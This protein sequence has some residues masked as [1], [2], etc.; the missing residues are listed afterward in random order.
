MWLCVY[1]SVHVCRLCM[2]LCMYMGCVRGGAGMWAVYVAVRACGLCTW[3]CV[4]VGCV[5]GCVW[6]ILTSAETAVQVM[7]VFCSTMKQIVF[8][9]IPC[10]VPDL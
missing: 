1:V 2:W 10:T 9:P 8:L 7:E 4:P 5:C 3:P 6:Q